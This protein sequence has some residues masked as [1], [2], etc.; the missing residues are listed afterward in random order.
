[1]SES[2][3]ANESDSEKPCGKL[4]GFC[5]HIAFH[6]IIKVLQEQDYL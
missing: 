2:H 4:F 5:M 6:I 3:L 1:M